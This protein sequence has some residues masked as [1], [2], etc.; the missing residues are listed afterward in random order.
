MLDND[1]NVETPDMLDN[2]F[3]VDGKLRQQPKRIEK[4]YLIACNELFCGPLSAAL[5]RMGTRPLF[6]SKSL[7]RLS[8]LTAYPPSGSIETLASW[9]PRSGAF[10]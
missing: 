9:T 5:L 1:W 6:A 7:L 4:P 2:D 10:R 8:P 3:V